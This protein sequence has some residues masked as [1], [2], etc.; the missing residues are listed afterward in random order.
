MFLERASNGNNACL[1][2]QLNKHPKLK[3]RQKDGASCF[4]FSKAALPGRGCE[5]DYLI[6]A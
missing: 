4:T 6:I 5:K 1:R 2:T 3:K